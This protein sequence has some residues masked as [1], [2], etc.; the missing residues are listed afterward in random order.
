[1]SGKLHLICMKGFYAKLRCNLND[2]LYLSETQ[3]KKLSFLIITTSFLTIFL[4]Y[5]VSKFSL[6]LRFQ[7]ITFRAFRR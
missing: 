7:L 2:I 5:F 3:K 6:K 4:N 1:M